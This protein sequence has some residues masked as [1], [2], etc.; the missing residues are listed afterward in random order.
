MANADSVVITGVGMRTPIGNDALQTAAA[1]RAGITRFAAW[2]PA[3]LEHDEA[4]GITAACLPEGSAD[5]H[6]IDK[7]AD[8]LLA[9]MH[10][11]LW[12]AGLFDFA[13]ARAARERVGVYI[14]LPYA[15][16]AGSDV[17]ALRAFAAE[18]AAPTPA[19]EVEL[20]QCEHAAGLI[21]LQHA[22]RDL[23]AGKNTYALVSAVDSQLQRDHLAALAALRRLKLP[24]RP[25][26]LIPGE[27]AAVLVVEL[28]RH[29]RARGVMPLAK[30]GLLASELEPV[31][32][33]PEH[34]IRAEAASR[35]LA[36]VLEDAAANGGVTR[37]LV[38]LSGERW[39][40]LEWALLETRCLHVLPRGWQLWHPAD[41]TGDLG[42]ASAL[43][44]V[45]V[46]LRAFARKYAGDGGILVF[47]ASAGGERAAAC[48][49][50]CAG[51]G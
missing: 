20:L 37:A 38:D 33:G 50:P 51:G 39:R 3:A 19:D 29:A 21:A 2:E 34:P 14:G 7:A 30:L 47:A 6:W 11:A 32:L 35:A 46:G 18:A 17:R 10:E 9:P 36:A 1:V 31:P 27:G 45:G 48:L 49:W 40:S 22:A 23:R 44:H 28:E 41:C 26:G 4:A 43:V 5:E 16:R 24:N 8:M 15:E 12:Q 25:D 42:A 13:H